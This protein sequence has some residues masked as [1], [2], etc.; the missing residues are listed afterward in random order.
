MSTALFW[1]SFQAA[2]YVK[3]KSVDYLPIRRILPNDLQNKGNLIWKEPKV[4][5]HQFK[6]SVK[7][8][9]NE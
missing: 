2:L 3:P 1:N 9:A 5:T 7:D 4:K 8:A 6:F